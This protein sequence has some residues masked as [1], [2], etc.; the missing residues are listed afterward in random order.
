MMKDILFNSFSVESSED[1][2]QMFLMEGQE[3]FPH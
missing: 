3:G 2:Q 1:L